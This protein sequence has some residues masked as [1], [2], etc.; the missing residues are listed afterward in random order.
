MRYRINPAIGKI[1]CPVVLSIES[2]EKEYANGQL[3]AEQEFDKNY[4]VNKLFA[5]DNKIVVVLRENDMI[6]NTNWIGE[7]QSFF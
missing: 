6:N 5:R 7:E 3:A 2:S 4:I 1:T